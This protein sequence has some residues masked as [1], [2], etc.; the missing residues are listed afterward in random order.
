M[1]PKEDEMWER[2]HEPYEP[3]M[4]TSTVSHLHDLMHQLH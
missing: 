2:F 1:V 4:L 3:F